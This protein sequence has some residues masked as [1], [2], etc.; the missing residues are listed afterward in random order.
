M[1][2]VKLD[3]G[4]LKS[5][6]TVLII[7]S[8]LILSL[9]IYV[10]GIMTLNSTDQTP[11]DLGKVPD[12]G[13]VNSGVTVPGSDLDEQ[14]AADPQHS[15]EDTQTPLN[16]EENKPGTVDDSKSQPGV[17]QPDP[18]GTPVRPSYDEAGNPPTAPGLVMKHRDFKAEPAKVAYLT[19][20][21]G[22]YPQTTPKILQILQDEGVKATFF[23]LGSRIE[24][25]PNL[26]KEIYAA[27]HAI[28]NHTYTHDYKE[29]YQT[30]EHFLREIQWT[31]DLIY[32]DI[33]IRPK[34]VRAPGGSSNFNVGYFNLMDS[35][36]YLMY[37]WNASN[38]DTT[39]ALLPVDA[40]VQNVINTTQGKNK[41]IVLMHDLGAKT[42]TVKALPQII[43]YLKQQGYEFG[44]LSPDVA[45]I[46]F[47]SGFNK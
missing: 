41:V 42:T 30:P 46:L 8:A 29:L 23:V 36:D 17:S 11:V 34:I 10:V 43:N 32:Q 15:E 20:D 1:S 38:D 7:I 33:G 12:Q 18:P 4:K 19:F 24:G 22:P 28:G 44:V 5:R 21:D 47:S 9:G 37:D 35:Q 31:E 26:L 27:G 2:T 6:T 45:P 16:G 40:L 13:P 25:N 39:Q 3:R 14:E